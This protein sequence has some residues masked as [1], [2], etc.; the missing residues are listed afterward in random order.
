M[1]EDRLPDRGCG[2]EGRAD[3]AP[4][5]AE[6]KQPFSPSSIWSPAGASCWLNPIGSQMF[7]EF[8]MWPT[9]VRLPGQR[10]GIEVDPGANEE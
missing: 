10:I 3:G 4:K 9:Q 5:Q 1:A 7:G 6:N 2:P 8:S